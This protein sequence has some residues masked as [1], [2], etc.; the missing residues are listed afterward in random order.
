MKGLHRINKKVSFF[1]IIA[2]LIVTILTL[3]AR[4]SYKKTNNADTNL[5]EAS[6]N[7]IQRQAFLNKAVETVVSDHSSGTHEDCVGYV[8]QVL[9]NCNVSISGGGSTAA[10]YNEEVTVGGQRIHPVA[11]YVEKGGATWIDALY[12]Q[13]LQPGDIIVGVRTS[14]KDGRTN[15]YKNGHMFIYLGNFAAST[16]GNYVSYGSDYGQQKLMQAYSALGTSHIYNQNQRGD[17]GVTT[18]YWYAEGN[19][20]SGKSP[21][22][23]GSGR[24]LPMVRNYNWG[25]Q[26]VSGSTNMYYLKVYRITYDTTPGEYTLRVGKLGSENLS[27]FIGGAEFTIER[28]YNGSNDKTNPDIKKTTVNN[29]YTLVE[30]RVI[31][32]TNWDDYRVT[33]TKGPD[34]YDLYN[35]QLGLQIRKELTANG[36]YRVKEVYYYSGA[37]NIA[38]AKNKSILPGHTCYIFPDG[39]PKIL[40]E[41]LPRDDNEQKSKA[42]AY[43]AVSDYNANNKVEIKYVGIDKKQGQYHLNV[44][45][46]E[47]SENMNFSDKSQNISGIT[48]NLNRYADKSE[49]EITA[50]SL[51]NATQNARKDTSKRT[52]G[53]ETIIDA[54]AIFENTTI[55][56]SNNGKWDVYTVSETITGNNAKYYK[57]INNILAN[58]RIGVYKDNYKVSYIRIFTKNSSGTW[59]AGPNSISQHH[60]AGDRKVSSYDISPN[61]IGIF[62]FNGDGKADFS[63]EINDQGS[64]IELTVVNPIYEGKYSMQIRKVEPDASIDDFDLLD[65]FDGVKFKVNGNYLQPT[66]SR[67]A[68]KGYANVVTD[69]QITK[70]NVGTLDEY[71]IEEIDLGDNRG[72]VKLAEPVGI[73]VGKGLNPEKTAYTSTAARFMKAPGKIATNNGKYV[74]QQFELEDGTKE[75][76]G[77]KVVNGMVTVAIPNNREGKYNLNIGKKSTETYCPNFPEEGHENE[78][79][80]SDY[81]SG[82]RFEVV[83]Y[84]NTDITTISNPRYTGG[85]YPASKDG[86]ATPVTFSNEADIAINNVNQPDCYVI[87]EIDCPA[88]YQ[89]NE[90]EYCIKVIKEKDTTSRTY[91]IKTIKIYQKNESTNRWDE[92]TIRGTLYSDPNGEHNSV[93]WGARSAVYNEAF[94]VELN[95]NTNTITFVMADQPIDGKYNFLLEKTNSRGVTIKEGT[96]TFK[97]YPYN[98]IGG[99]R[100]DV[101]LSGKATLYD[102]NNNAISSETLQNL[103]T[104]NGICDTLSNLKIQDADIG[105]TYYFLIHEEQAPGAYTKIGYDVVVPVKFERSA[106]A[107]KA[108]VDEAN[109]FAIFGANPNENG[110]SGTRMNLDNAKGSTVGVKVS[111]SGASIQTRIPN[112]QSGSYNFE[113]TK[114]D[115]SGQIIKDEKTRFDVSIFVNE[116]LTGDEIQISNASGIINTKNLVATTGVVE[117]LDGIIITNEDI[118]KTY[119]FVVTETEAP[120]EFTKIDYEVVVPISYTEVNGQYKATKGEPFAVRRNDRGEVVDRMSLAE[121]G[122]ATTGVVSTEQVDATINVNVPDVHKAGTYDFRIVKVDVSGNVIEDEEAEFNISVYDNEDCIGREVTLSKLVQNSQGQMVEEEMQPSELKGLKTVTGIV[123][124]V[125]KNIVIHSEDVTSNKTYYFRIHETK[126]PDE[127]TE[128]DYDVVVPISFTESGSDYVAVKGEAYAITTEGDIK[129]LAEVGSE[130]TGVVS[131]A[132]VDAAIIVN[133]PN[134]HITGK[135]AVNLLKVNS[136]DNS[137]IANAIFN[138]ASNPV[139]GIGR[140]GVRT[141]SDGMLDISNGEVTIVGNNVQA[142]SKETNV[143]VVDT[144]TIT[145]AS[146]QSYMKLKWPIS[147]SVE[148]AEKDGEY[149]VSRLTLKELFRANSANRYK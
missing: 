138:I 137:P 124:E 24:E 136:S 36:Q 81:I 122:S 77:I 49:S 90:Q 103:T 114:T 101:H 20:N 57:D 48:F 123:E 95:K 18:N 40:G 112:T 58:L 82:A 31:N 41:D 71:Y 52:S 34:G 44:T 119:Y 3:C 117:K 113:I 22:T 125:A 72:I 135:Y 87:K 110:A 63:V 66:T 75:N 33:E 12:G 107:Y 13:N 59:A 39:T 19:I 42:M 115:V 11:S 105:Q 146:I 29:D 14:S 134:K 98:T 143:G 8:E 78:I 46:K 10:W 120:D 133:V 118:N 55:S 27:K 37:Q 4:S 127:Y 145:E 9:G 65:G 76:V 147:I 50:A 140:D 96:A 69:E 68:F 142:G 38:G 26:E 116:N 102:S 99:A 17:T 85:S 149:V 141:R 130:T 53:N 91:K 111:Q 86:E 64:A 43:I 1:G 51:G 92:C 132:Q 89:K 60:T 108:T 16:T 129:T 106:Y 94:R 30:T 139:K 88:G 148:K 109:A 84:L 74:T 67:G 7:I 144:Y 121:A 45:K 15:D 32:S 6:Y 70:A 54:G 128:I 126:A 104:V 5:G 79:K 2:V 23:D 25:A 93:L 28:R 131:T 21:S 61:E 80:D 35:K 97:V 73:Y 83:Q 56:N 62:D 100:T 47:Q